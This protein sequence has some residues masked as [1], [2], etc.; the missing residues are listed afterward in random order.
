METSEYEQSLRACINQ[1]KHVIRKL[2]ELAAEAE[3]HHTTC[4]VV[5]TG[6]T[7][8]GVA[9]TGIMIGSLLAAPFTGGASLA[10]TLAAAGC[11]VGGAATNI[12]TGVVDRSK[13]KGIIAE[14]QSLID[15][16]QKVAL[17]LKEQS[18][19]FSRTVEDL[20]SNGMLEENA[21]NLVFNGMKIIEKTNMIRFLFSSIGECSFESERCCYSRFCT[22]C[23]YSI[24]S[25]YSD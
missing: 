17:K 2:S 6:G 15:S 20:I 14:I 23:T 18:E 25:S 1:N 19:Y 8:A 12:V 22:C 5:K 21:V 11:S 9:G 3:S 16:R 7:L 13:S 4:N 10:V 24:R